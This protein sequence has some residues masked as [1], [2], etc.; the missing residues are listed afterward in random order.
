MDKIESHRDLK[1]WQ[2]GMDLAVEAYRLA[3][4][5]PKSEE[6]R[7]TNQ[8]LRAAA[9]VPAN[10]AEGHAR[11]TR[12]DYAHFVSVARGSVAE[13]ETFLLLAIRAGIL[14]KDQTDLALTL[15]DELSRMLNSLRQRLILNS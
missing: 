12:R 2:K 15:T 8:L 11:G 14:T 6:Y 5:L 9:S 1:V 13:T 3:K 7:L 10:I 4:I